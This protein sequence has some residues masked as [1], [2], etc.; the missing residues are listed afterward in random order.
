MIEHVH[1]QNKQITSTSWPDTWSRSR[2]TG[3]FSIYS[4]TPKQDC[5]WLY[6]KPTSAESEINATIFCC[7]AKPFQRSATCFFFLSS[8]GKALCLID[9][10]AD[11][12]N[13]V[14]EIADSDVV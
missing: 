1:Y 4:T 5:Y 11:V 9:P 14:R 2:Q 12:L 6:T 8:H 13:T 10:V 3:T 7:L